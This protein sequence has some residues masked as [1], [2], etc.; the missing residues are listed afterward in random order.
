M[1]PGDVAVEDVHCWV[2]PLLARKRRVL[3]V[4]CGS[5]ELARL[6]A[7]DGLEVTALDLELADPAP[8]DRLT[9]VEADFLGFE[10]DPFDAVLFTRSLHHIYPLE[11]AVEQALRLCRGGGLLLVDEFDRDAADAETARWYYEVKE[12]LVAA[13][14]HAADR[15]EGLP[16]DDPAARWRAEHLHVP[17]L[18]SGAEMLAAVA[19][20]FTRLDTSRG[21]YL[22]RSIAAGVEASERGGAVASQVYGAEIRRLQAAALAPVGL[23]IGAI[24]PA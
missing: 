22:Y 18:H 16:D 5:G 19:D 12:L 15:L 21:V 9:W 20:R 7:A 8:A 23:R 10:D 6:L 24:A 17:P 13:G 1:L 11:R 2:A 3:E 4:G 14:V